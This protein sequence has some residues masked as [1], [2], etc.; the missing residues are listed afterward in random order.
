LWRKKCHG[1]PPPALR[2]RKPRKELRP[3]FDIENRTL[4]VGDKIVKCFSQPAGNQ[5]TIL[6]VFQ[7]MNWPD[8]IDDPLP[9]NGRTPP[10]RRLHDAVQA[11]N[12][13]QRYAL[14]R[15]RCCE[16]GT[17]VRWKLVATPA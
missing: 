11:L 1:A 14:I 4:Y 10:T 13:N 17:Q 15:F 7:E 8:W 2:K 16:N 6:K 9:P 3:W 12:H 5:E